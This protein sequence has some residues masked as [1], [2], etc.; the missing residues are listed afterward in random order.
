LD[1]SFKQAVLNLLRILREDPFDKS[2]GWVGKFGLHDSCLLHHGNI[3]YSTENGGHVKN[4]YE[5]VARDFYTE[6]PIVEAAIDSFFEKQKHIRLSWPKGHGSFSYPPL[7]IGKKPKASFQQEVY[8]WPVKENYEVDSTLNGRRVV[9]NSRGFVAIESDSSHEVHRDLNL[10]FGCVAINGIN[11]YKVNESDIQS[12]RIGPSKIDLESEL[13]PH[14]IRAKLSKADT[15][16]DI[17]E[18]QEV[19]VQILCDSIRQAELISTSAISSDFLLWFEGY[20]HYQDNEYDQSFIMSWI[21]VEKHLYRL[22]LN[23]LT[24]LEKKKRLGKQKKE[25]L[26]KLQSVATLLLFLRAMNRINERDYSSLTE[27]NKKR[28]NFVHKGASLT[29]RDS[30]K[31]LRCSERIIKNLLGDLS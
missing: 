6:N 16:D 31:C 14:S 15:Y 7:W 26:E 8:G 11:C 23:H 25:N 5:S 3:F 22:F 13:P 30:K 21:V 29:S 24:E 19:P 1:N 2:V 10:F 12:A 4:D 17:S 20:N 27:L 28:N 9:I 18:F